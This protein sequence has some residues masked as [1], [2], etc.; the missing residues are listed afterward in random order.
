M[1]MGEI[2]ACA[3]QFAGR[4]DAAL[5]LSG[6][7][8]ADGVSAEREGAKFLAAANRA[9][10]SLAVRYLPLYA[11]ETVTGGETDFSVFSRTVIRVEG[12]TDAAG[13]KV[14]FRVADGRIFLPRGKTVVR[15]RYLP[16]YAGAED[17]CDYREGSVTLELLAE[18]AAA[19]FSVAEGRYEDADMWAERMLCSVRAA[20]SRRVRLPAR[21]KWI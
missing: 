9:V 14:K 15:Y 19:E 13:G 6:G 17:E 7:T 10:R 21:K 18:A 3:A 20:V 8:P 11:E 12:A 5:F 2:A 16:A 4:E 1:K